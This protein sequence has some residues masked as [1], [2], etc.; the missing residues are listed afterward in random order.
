MLMELLLVSCARQ[1]GAWPCLTWSLGVG[2]RPLVREQM[3]WESNRGL[4]AGIR[5]VQKRGVTRDSNVHGAE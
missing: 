4:S 3:D 2:V 1:V 5:W